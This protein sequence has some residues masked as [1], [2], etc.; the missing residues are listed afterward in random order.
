MTELIQNLSRPL[1]QLFM[2]IEMPWR[3]AIILL[4]LVPVLSW[5]FLRAFPW[6]ITQLSKI[7]LT[8]KVPDLVLGVA[9]LFGIV[10]LYPQFLIARY[11]RQHGS[12]VSDFTYI[13]EDIVRATVVFVA[14]VCQLLDK[15]FQKSQPIFSYALKIK[16]FYS[17]ILLII[18]SLFVC[19]W[20]LR[21]YIQDN[22]ATKLIDS[23]LMSWYSLENWAIDNQEKNAINTSSPKTF[24]ENYFESI[25]KQ[26]YQVA[27]NSL[28]ELYRKNKFG[29]Y[30]KFLDWWENQVEEVKVYQFYPKLN[31]TKYATVNV[32]MQYLMKSRKTK[33]KTKLVSYEL[34]WDK[35]GNRWL[36]NNSQDLPK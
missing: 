30:I 1:W 31:A 14:K 8:F 25:D 33:S 29:N 19:T 5:L 2:P 34:V 22:E 16:W 7:M 18:P 11:L 35:Q 26:H 4:L 3:S 32:S 6:M 20:Y 9:Q 10:L 21:P 28:S 12:Q 27:W 23:S 17:Q 13:F 15:I 24:L 36:I